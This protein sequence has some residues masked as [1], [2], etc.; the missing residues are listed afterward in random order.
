MKK[1][2]LDAVISEQKKHD[3]EFADHYQRELLINEISKM[4]VSL[5]KAAH[6]TQE[7]LAKKASTTQPVIARLE[8]GTDNRIPSLALLARIARASHA[9]LHLSFKQDER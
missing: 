3:P 7:E 2:T 1:I 8:S 5:R 6:L 9:K 4:V